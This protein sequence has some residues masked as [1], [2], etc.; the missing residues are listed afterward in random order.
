MAVVLKRGSKP[1]AVSRLMVA[2][3]LN[4]GIDVLT[5]LERDA[6]DAKIGPRPAGTTHAARLVD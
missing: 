3:R 4:A 1:E 6:F 2:M 5:V